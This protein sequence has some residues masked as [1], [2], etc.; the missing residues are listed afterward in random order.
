MLVINER[1]ESGPPWNFRF[2][3]Q[4][5]I[6]GSPLTWWTLLMPVGYFA[7]KVI[8]IAAYSIFLSIVSW[9]RPNSYSTSININTIRQELLPSMVPTCLKIICRTS[10]SQS[11]FAISALHPSTFGLFLTSSLDVTKQFFLL[12]WSKFGG[13]LR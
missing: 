11:R 6:K 10:N 4:T 5:V 2:Q 8:V 7:D 12:D 13:S 1:H 9:P 3:E